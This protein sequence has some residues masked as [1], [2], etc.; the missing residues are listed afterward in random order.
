MSFWKTL[1]QF[2]HGLT[3]AIMTRLLNPKILHY[4]WA[5]CGL[6]CVAS[7]LIAVLAA[8]FPAPTQASWTA[9]HISK[10]YNH[11][12]KG[13]HAASVMLMF[14]GTVYLPYTVVISDQM[15]RIPRV[16]WILPHLQIACGIASTLGFFVPGVILGIAAYP[17]ERC[18]EQMML[19]NDAFWL[20]LLMPFQALLP[21]YAA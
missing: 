3:N 15:R 5:C 4:A 14:A 18:V 9:G 21:M 16:P 11:H 8:D 10:H 19:L 1:T 2:E 20:C 13:M 7:T 12:Q 6:I 17:R